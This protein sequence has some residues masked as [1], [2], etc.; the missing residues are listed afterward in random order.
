MSKKRKTEYLVIHGPP[1]S[2][3]TLN[4]HAL[5]EHYKCDH[6][7]DAHESGIRDATGRVMILTWDPDVRGPSGMRYAFKGAV[8]IPIHEARTML[9][10]RWIEPRRDYHASMPA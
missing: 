6:V 8:R 9:G 1:M 2:G 10:D 5:K 7:F 4:A 3:K